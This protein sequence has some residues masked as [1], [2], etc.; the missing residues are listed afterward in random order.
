MC[1][2]SHLTDE[3]ANVLAG[4]ADERVYFIQS[5]RWVAHPKALQ[6]LEHLNKMLKHPRTTRMP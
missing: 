4:A 5:K 3:A 6:I 1:K 2:P